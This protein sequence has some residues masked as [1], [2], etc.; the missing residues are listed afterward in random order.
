MHH[1]DFMIQVNKKDDLMEYPYLKECHLLPGGFDSSISDPL[2]KIL[3]PGF[4][5]PRHKIDNYQYELMCSK[6]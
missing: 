5:M 1:A 3:S 6:S 4:E 2:I